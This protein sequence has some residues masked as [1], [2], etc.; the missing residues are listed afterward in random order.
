MCTSGQNM[1]CHLYVN[2]TH[3][4][5]HDLLLF[6]SILR[7]L[8]TKGYMV[9]KENWIKANIYQLILYIFAGICRCRALYEYK[10]SQSD[11]LDILP[12]DIITLTAKLDGGWWQ[13]E[14]HNKTGIFPA[15]Y[16]EE[17]GWPW[18]QHGLWIGTLINLKKLLVGHLD[19]FCCLCLTVWKKKHT[20]ACTC[21]VTCLLMKRSAFKWVFQSVICK[22]KLLCTAMHNRPF[23][24]CCKQTSSNSRLGWKK[25]NDLYICMELST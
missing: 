22:R 13:G 8:V 6:S 1:K 25:Y 24:H 10:A 19:G 15:S 11:E 2:I 5:C 7:Y 23:L 20:H 17:I 18:A 16:V 9:L 4:N 3:C 21:L 14:L 12:G